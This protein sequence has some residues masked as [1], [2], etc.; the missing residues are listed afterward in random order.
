EKFIE[1]PRHIEIQ[2]LADE[3]GHILAFPERDCS[4]QRRHQKLIEETPSPAVDACVRRKLQKIARK[5][6]RII[7]Y[8]NAGTIEF[9]MGGRHVYFME[10]NTRIQVEHPITEMITGFDLV[11]NQI[12]IASGEKMRYH[13]RFVP[14]TGHSIECRINAENPAR[15]FLPSP[16]KI[17]KLVLPGGPGIR[18]DTHIYEGY[19]VPPFYDSLLAKLI[20]YG[21]TRQE[22]ITRMQRALNEMKIEGISTTIDFYKVVLDHPVFQSG[23]YYVGWLEK[24]LNDMKN[25]QAVGSAAGG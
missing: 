6:C 4:L 10:M 25:K 12:E 22:A 19:V 11:K 1:R 16:G 21:R 7:N 23:R 2:V 13:H 18:V 20:S 15:D 9:L 3:Y 14:F 24:L 17:T 5:I 8:K